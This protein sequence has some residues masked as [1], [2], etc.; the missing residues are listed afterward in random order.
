M[1][2]AASAAYGLNAVRLR[3]FNAAGSHPDATIGEAH[4]PETHLIPIALLAAAGK[5]PR[6]K[7]FGTD[8]D[9]PD[10]TCIRDYIH[11][12]DLVEA[13]ILALKHLEN[14]GK[15][16]LFNVGT[17]KGFSVKEVVS[18]AE[19]VTGKSLDPELADRRPGD[20]AVLTADSSK[21]QSA[22]GWKPQRPDL[23]TMIEDAWRWLSD[24]AYGPNR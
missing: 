4:D 10:G 12:C 9:T 20:P 11:V 7:I 14:G 19:M 5:R 22:W 16:D 21:I 1:I 13:H 23:E 17:G 6:M 3:Y 18:A 24:P 8:Y 15:S 2:E